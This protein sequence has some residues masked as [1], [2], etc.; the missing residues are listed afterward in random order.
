MKTRVLAKVSER[1]SAITCGRR[2][3]MGGEGMTVGRNWRPAGNPAL[4]S[5]FTV[6]ELILVLALSELHGTA[7]FQIALV[8][9]IYC[10]I[11]EDWSGGDS[12]FLLEI[13][14]TQFLYQN[15][16]TKSMKPI[17]TL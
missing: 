2:M 7:Q 14:K 12:Y 4:S 1:A 10:V 16:T 3:T 11:L 8:L 17:T 6:G 13:C 9:F 5:S 15:S